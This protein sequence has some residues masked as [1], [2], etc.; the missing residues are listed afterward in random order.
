MPKIAIAGKGGTGKTTV[1]GTLARCLARRGHRVWA[2]DADSSPNLALTL[3][4]SREDRQGLMPLPRS[5]LRETQD[6][7][8]KRKMVL[9]MAPSEVA[10]QF[11]K[12]GPDGVTLLLMGE[13][14]HA[15]A[16]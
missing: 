2:V 3:G 5:I 4:F 11:G 9:D 8:G 14:R 12:E 16:G 6:E 15:G 10:R 1:A 13:I 7:E